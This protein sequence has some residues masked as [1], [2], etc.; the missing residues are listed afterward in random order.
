VEQPKQAISRAISGPLNRAGAATVTPDRLRRSCVESA[1]RIP[2]ASGTVLG[3]AVVLLLAVGAV[4]IAKGSAAYFGEDMAPF[5]IEKLPLPLEDVWM[6]A[7]KVHV[8]AAAFSLPACLALLSTALVRRAP[9]FH[10]WLGR[11]TA[12]AILLV[13]VPSGLYLALFAKYGLPSTAGFVLSGIVVAV[14]MVQGVRTARARR[15]VEHRRWALHVLA[16]LSV[17]VTSRAMLAGFD[18][19][20][21]GEE[22][23]YLV[24][25]WLPVL[26][27][28]I[29]VPLIAPRPTAHLAR[30]SH[31]APV[32]R[33]PERRSL[34]ARLAHGG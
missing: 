24:S 19:A 4:V 2:R 9:R 16:Q 8:V 17:A 1:V 28:A 22:L 13:L 5:I 31:E 26:G 18:A 3:F 25:L 30:R 12:A 33:D 10:R 15:F 20:G 6:L 7:V 32:D 27:G 14:A 21:V 11:V 34:A 29:V 23:A